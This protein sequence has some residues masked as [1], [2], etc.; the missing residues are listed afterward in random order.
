MPSTAKKRLKKLDIYLDKIGGMGYTETMMSRLENG[1]SNL[2]PKRS[3]GASLFR[4]CSSAIRPL[5]L[6]VLLCRREESY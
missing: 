5:I 2:E 3:G 6:W 1:V 4:V